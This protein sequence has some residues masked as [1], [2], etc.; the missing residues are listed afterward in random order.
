[1]KLRNIVEMGMGVVRANYLGHRMPL[2]V[3]LSVTNHC[4]SH[5]R[6]C[7]IPLRKQRELTTDEIFS[8]I[9]QIRAM[10]CTRL[11]FWGGEPLVR[12]DIAEL[13][14]YASFKGMYTTMDTNGFLVPDRIHELSKL[15]HMIIAFDGDKE[16]HELNREP[17]SHERAL[18]AIKVASNRLPF[19]SITV[20]SKHNL[21]SIDYI[22][23]IARKYNFLTTFQVVHH[24]ERLGVDVHGFVPSNEDY[25]K[26]IRKLILEKRRGAPIASTLPYL[27]FLLAWPDYSVPMLPYRMHGLKCWAGQLY[28]NV[29]ANG[30]VYPCSLLIELMEAKNFLDVGFKEAFDAVK[31]VPCKACDAS[32]FT[33]YNYLYSLDRKVITG[34]LKAMFKSRK[35]L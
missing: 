17:G 30:D 14:N 12:D 7:N 11:G 31:K 33:E 3:M 24:N 15:E 13:I 22:L 34:W 10:G 6:Y 5:C 35:S 27:E 18:E 16:A 32:C 28:C 25:R 29:D 4:T 19:W 20:L 26:A 9:D 2:N 1:M 8:L 23:D 21:H